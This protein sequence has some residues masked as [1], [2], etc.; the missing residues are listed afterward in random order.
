[1]ALDATQENAGSRVAEMNSLAR[2]PLVCSEKP[3]DKVVAHGAH[4]TVGRTG[5]GIA[6]KR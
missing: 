3:G 5:Y 4:P 6:S 1:M 2:N